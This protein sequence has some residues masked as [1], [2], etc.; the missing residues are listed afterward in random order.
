MGR[1]IDGFAR[2]EMKECGGRSWLPSERRDAVLGEERR[3]RELE[4]IKRNRHKE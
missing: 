2:K 4:K 3:I 1:M